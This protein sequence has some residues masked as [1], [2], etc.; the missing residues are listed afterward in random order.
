MIPFSTYILFVPSFFDYAKWLGHLHVLR[1]L[2]VFCHLKDKYLLFMVSLPSL[3][4]SVISLS[5]CCLKGTHN[6]TPSLYSPTR[7]AQCAKELLNETRFVFFFLSCRKCALTGTS[8]FCLH[9]VK[10][11]EKGDWHN[12]S[13]NSRV[14]VSLSIVFLWSYL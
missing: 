7:T 11:S 14:R 12:L 2:C 9:R 8:R 5:H 3:T 6:L 4:Q 1:I 10:L 13:R